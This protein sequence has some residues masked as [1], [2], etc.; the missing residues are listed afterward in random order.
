[1]TSRDSKIQFLYI[2]VQQYRE[3]KCRKIKRAE[4]SAVPC[5]RAIFLKS[6]S[7]DYPTFKK[8]RIYYAAVFLFYIFT[9]ITSLSSSYSY[10]LFSL[11]F[12]FLD[13]SIS[14]RRSWL[15][16]YFIRIDSTNW[17]NKKFRNAKKNNLENRAQ[18][19]HSWCLIIITKK[20]GVVFS[21]FFFLRISISLT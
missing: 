9:Y 11:Y 21:W 2:N 20:L 5:C 10:S 1:M 16:I 7:S 19:F 13:S 15:I 12:I 3:R 17:L 4:Y 14:T 18:K 8:K 6:S